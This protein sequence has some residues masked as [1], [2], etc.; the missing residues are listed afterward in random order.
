[1]RTTWTIRI[2]QGYTTDAVFLNTDGTVNHKTNWEVRAGDYKAA[3][4]KEGIECVALH[5]Q[6]G[7]KA[8]LIKNN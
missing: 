2:T 6:H 5:N 4:K 8:E 3:T 7:G 1:M